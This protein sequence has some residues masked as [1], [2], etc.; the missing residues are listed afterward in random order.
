MMSEGDGIKQRLYDM[1]DSSSGVFPGPEMT[2]SA[3]TGKSCSG[4]MG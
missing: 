4:K 2:V 3:P 1:M